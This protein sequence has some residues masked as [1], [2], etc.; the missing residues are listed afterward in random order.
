MENTPL[1]LNSMRF[2]TTAE[3]EVSWIIITSLIDK[4]PKLQYKFAA[5]FVDDAIHKRKT[6]SKNINKIGSPDNAQSRVI[7][8]R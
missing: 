4:L 6:D 1:L 5:I 3:E 2:L 8:A 7:A